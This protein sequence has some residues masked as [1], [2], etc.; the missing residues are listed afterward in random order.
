MPAKKST[1]KVTKRTRV[2]SNYSHKRSETQLLIEQAALYR[3][4]VALNHETELQ[5]MMDVAVRV[6]A[7]L[8]NVELAAIAL[9]DEGGDTF[10]ARQTSVGRPK[11]FL[12]LNISLSIQIT[13]CLTPYATTR[14]SPSPMN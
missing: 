11:F 3:L 6:A 5:A 10:R 2:G 8:F 12:S 14:L 1:P 4:S 13:V 9:V 7:E